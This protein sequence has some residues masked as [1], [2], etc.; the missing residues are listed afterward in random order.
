MQLD[1]LLALCRVIGVQITKQEIDGIFLGIGQGTATL[2]F[3]LN[4]GKVGDDP[5]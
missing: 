5:K 2:R 3:E 4:P 1:G